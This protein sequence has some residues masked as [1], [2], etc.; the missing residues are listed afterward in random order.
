MRREGSGFGCAG[1]TVGSQVPS[2]CVREKERRRE[3]EK[4]GGRG[5][6]LGPQA[7][8]YLL[9]LRL[10]FEVERGVQWL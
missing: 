4:E 5:W 10:G 2:V 3:S 1:K 7:Q 6:H 9:A 8:C